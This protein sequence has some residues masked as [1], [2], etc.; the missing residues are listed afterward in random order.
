MAEGH[1]I[2]LGTPVALGVDHEDAERGDGEV[3]D[4]RAAA[5]H[6]AVVEDDHLGAVTVTSSIPHVQEGSR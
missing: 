3:V 5:G 2:D 1:E 4:I 6:A